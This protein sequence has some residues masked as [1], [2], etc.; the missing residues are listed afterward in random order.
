MVMVRAK[1]LRVNSLA[2]AA[3]TPSL[4]R[5][6]ARNL[7]VI[8]PALTATSDRNGLVLRSR[9]SGDERKKNTNRRAMFFLVPG[10]LNSDSASMP[11][12]EL[13]RDEEPDTSAD[14]CM[15]RKEC[16][17]ESRQIFRTNAN[18]LSRSVSAT[19][20][21]SVSQSRTPTSMAPPPEMA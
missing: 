6:H 9:I 17:K 21:G 15:R 11:L 10:A 13:F 14:C 20:R 1:C 18:A 5:D 7:K 16:V 4:V 3:V 2:C 8:L 12:N 19:P